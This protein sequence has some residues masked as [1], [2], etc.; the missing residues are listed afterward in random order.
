[1]SKIPS[2]Y[3]SVKIVY[4]VALAATPIWGLGGLLQTIT[5]NESGLYNDT[6]QKGCYLSLFVTPFCLASSVFSIHR[7]HKLP[8]FIYLPLIPI[9]AY[10][11]CYSIFWKDRKKPYGEYN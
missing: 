6:F 9:W 1:M 11:F 7:G 4:G 5:M 8:F 3:T 10:G 2:F